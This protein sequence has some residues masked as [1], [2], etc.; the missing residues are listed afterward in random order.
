MNENYYSILEID[1]N[2]SE[3]EIKKS[4]KK[5][6]LKYHPDKNSGNNEACEK[7]KEISMAYNILS[8]KD[9][10]CQYDTIGSVDF[11]GKDPF[12]VFNNIFQQHI[13]SFMNMKYDKD[14]NI[15]NIF[16]NISGIPENSFPFG[17]VH[18]KVH[19]FPTDSFNSEERINYNYD[20]NDDNYDNDNYNYNNY[21]EDYL[22]DNSSINNLLNNLFKKKMKSKVNKKIESKIIY[23][24]PDDIVYNINVSLED[25]YNQKTKIITITRLRKKEGSYVNKKKKIEIP[26]YGKEILLEGEG[27]EMKNYKEKGNILINI[28]NVKDDNFKRINDYDILTTKE[29]SINQIYKSFIYELS[30]PKDKIKV[31][32][33]RLK[34]GEFMIQKIYKKGLPYKNDENELC[35]GNLYILY[36][37]IFP[38]NIEDL[39]NI[40][41]E[42]DII[43]NGIDIIN[44]G[45]DII[46]N[47]INNEINYE[48]N[49]ENNNKINNENNNE[50]NNE[51]NNNYYISYNCLIDEI[52][53]ND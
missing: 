7:F 20:N 18:I 29:I 9:K 5:L 24:K 14:I 42:I 31:K 3:D 40:N 22:N 10:R 35:F 50:I 2:A 47:E 28:F 52:F 51:I 25:I 43:N 12:S 16:S 34:D 37:I 27:H 46:N 13:N 21:D 23:N 44:N 4:Y 49:N 38:K 8:D 48:I 30:L 1:K 11:D 26:L 36:K 33:E 6:A 15:G 45:I 17:G 19:T 53:Q 32:C 41:N 39:K